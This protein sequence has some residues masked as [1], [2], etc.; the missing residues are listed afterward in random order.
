MRLCQ[1]PLMSYRG[2]P[3]WPPEWTWVSGSYDKRPDG[4]AGVLENVSL[5]VV[6]DHILFLTMSYGGGRYVATL[7]FDSKDFCRQVCELLKHH[8]G[9]LIG[10]IAEL[11]VP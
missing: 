10:S 4:E 11:D 3:A 2:A 1:H 6:N 7:T 5:S 8:Y 9:W